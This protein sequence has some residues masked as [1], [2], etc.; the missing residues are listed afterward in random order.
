V[1]IH[2]IRHLRGGSSGVVPVGSWD[3]STSTLALLAALVSHSRTSLATMFDSTGKLTY[4][5]NNLLLQSNNFSNAVWTSLSTTITSGFSDPVGGTAAWRLQ[6][7]ANPW[8]HFQTLTLSTNT[9]EAFWVKSNTGGTQTFRLVAGAVSSDLTA[10]TSWQRFTFTSS[11]TG[12]QAVGIT[13]D[14]LGNT[15]DLLIYAPTFSAVTYETSPRTADQVI[16]TAAAY[17]G[18]RVDYDPSTLAAKGLLIEE[19]R[20]NL[21]LSS[22]D[23]SSASWTKLNV[24]ATA[25]AA[26]SPDGTTSATKLAETAVTGAHLEFNAIAQSITSGTSYTGSTFV[27]AAERSIV[28]VAVELGGVSYGKYIDLSAGTIGSTFGSAPDSSSIQNVGNGWYRV[29]ITKAASSTGATGFITTYGVLTDGGSV[30]YLGVAGSGYY[31]WGSQFE[32]VSFATSYI[33]TAAASVTRAADVVQFTGAALT[34]LQGSAASALVETTGWSTGNSNVPRIIGSV[35]SKTPMT[36]NNST[37][38]ISY[39]GTTGLTA[40]VPSGNY[41]T[42]QRTGSAWSAAGRSLV[43]S[44]GT[45]ASD[46]ATFTGMTSIWLGGDNG[47][48]P[49]LSAWIKSFAIYTTRLPDATLQ[50]RSIVGAAF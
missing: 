11:S 37:S 36:V 34:A 17:Y 7:T 33:P 25:N 40:N 6:G 8:S 14:S 30:S 24:T 12:S 2:G 35:A 4:A 43:V 20:T 38:A 16:T 21:A 28:I 50:A 5:P 48:S 18:P 19:A 13:R 44:G 10:T 45:V 49:Y 41:T 27:K 15:A 9:L 3:A 26:T 31:R 29:V 46:A 42:T 32:V 1:G 39:N 23:H 47:G 22:G